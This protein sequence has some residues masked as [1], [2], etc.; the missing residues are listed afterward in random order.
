MGMIT[1][2]KIQMLRYI[3][4]AAGLQHFT[5]QDSLIAGEGINIF[6]KI[7]EKGHAMS[8]TF[9]FTISKLSACLP[10]NRNMAAWHPRVV[11]ILPQYQIN[12]IPRVAQWLAQMGHESGDFRFLS[13]NLNYSADALRRVFGR[14]F[15][16]AEIAAQYHRQPERIANRA[17]A[18]R[19]GNGPESSGDGWRYRG[20]GL[21]QITGRA[22]YRDASIA[23][24]GDENVLLREP[25]ILAEPDGAIRSAC[26]FWNSRALNRLADQHDTV[27]VSRRINGGTNGLSDR[28][29]RYD[30]ALRV[31]RG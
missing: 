20:R 13:E 27:G 6:R 12:T 11:H 25:E 24:Y 26:W 28:Q 1:K 18:N 22:N 4:A 17:Y 8:F 10:T 7:L 3:Q 19:I 23:L 16:T 15:P 30:Q 5:N 9:D 2:S 21:I 31:L 14:H 29:F